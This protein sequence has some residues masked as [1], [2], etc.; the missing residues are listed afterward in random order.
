MSTIPNHSTRS[1][2]MNV[3][4]L[5]PDR[6][7]AEEVAAV[8]QDYGFNSLPLR[9]PMD[10]LEHVEKLHIDVV[11]LC[12]DIPHWNAAELAELLYNVSR[13]WLEVL[14]IANPPDGL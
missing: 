12:A 8:L 3:L 9:N 5:H 7:V 13:E 14:L 10:A 4:I 2:T 11:L 1:T 6:V